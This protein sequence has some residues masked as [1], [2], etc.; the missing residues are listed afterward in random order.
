MRLPALLGLLPLLATGCQTPPSAMTP[1]PPP[2]PHAEPVIVARADAP[3]ELASGELLRIELPG[4]PSTGYTWA[5]DGALPPQLSAVDGLP[6]G[7]AAPAS[8]R[9]M[10]GAPQAQWLHFRAV[11]AGEAELRL[12]WHRPWETDA[13]PARQARYRITVR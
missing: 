6:G 3:T 8:D 13:A 10:V 4:N 2:L 7:P 1:P 11:Q 9:P 12:R 5:V